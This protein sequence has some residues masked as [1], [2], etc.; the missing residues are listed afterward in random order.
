MSTANYRILLSLGGLLALLP[1]S[2]SAQTIYIPDLN[3]RTWLNGQVPGSVDVNGYM[4]TAWTMQQTPPYPLAANI[5]ITW[6]PSDLTGIQY[7]QNIVF[8]VEYTATATSTVLP[9]F[10][11]SMEALFLNHYP[12]TTLP[13]LPDVINQLEVYDCPAL[14]TLPPFLQPFQML[15]LSHL[16]Q[17]SSLPPLA[18][19]GNFNSQINLL[20]LP[21][22]TSLPT[23]SGPWMSMS[24]RSLPQVTSL[25]TLPS[26]VRY[27]TLEDMPTFTTLPAALPADLQYLWCRHL[28]SLTGLPT[29]APPDLRNIE[30]LD[31]PL[32]TDMIGGL[33]N[34]FSYLLLEDL[35]LFNQP[36]DLPASTTALFLRELPL[37]PL[38]VPVL[39]PYFLELKEL[40]LWTSIPDTLFAQVSELGLDSMLT[41][42]SLPTVLSANLD[43]VAV[44]DCPNLTCLPHLPNNFRI[45]YQEGGSIT[46]VPN[47]TP[48]WDMGQN[49]P[50]CTPLNS[51]CALVN[52]L[53]TGHIYHDLNAN[54]Q[55][56]AGEPPAPYVMVQESPQN[57]LTSGDTSG[58][59]ELPL[60]PV[61]HTLTAASTNPYVVSIAPASHT[62]ALLNLTDVDS[63]N[64]FGVVLQPNV[65]DLVTTITTDPARPGFE[66]EVWVQCTNV[67]TVP[68]G[69][70]VSFTFDSDQSWVN[71]T[72]TP[73]T[74]TGNTATWSVAPLPLGGSAVF[75][76]TLHT[77]SAVA[78]GTAIGHTASA[79]PI[80]TDATPLDNVFN[81]TDSVVGSYD[82]NDKRVVPEAMLPADVAAGERLT[83]TI[84]FQNTGTY[85]AERVVITDALSSDLVHNSL[86]VTASSHVCTWVLVDGVLRFTF[87]PINLPDSASD[88][89]GSNGFVTFSIRPSATLLPG[90]QVHNHA[91]IF[92]D[93]N[94]PVVTAP[95]VFTVIDLSGIAEVHADDLLIFPNPATDQVFVARPKDVFGPMHIQLLDPSGRSIARSTHNG[96]GAAALSVAGCASGAYVLEVHSGTERWHT[97]LHVQ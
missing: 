45:L 97:V 52:P 4:D 72:P 20:D 79:E 46:C 59:F 34:D 15:D 90:E 31:L 92:F 84:R 54:G 62:A 60:D 50:L 75:A 3:T 27:L 89:S 69:G 13:V 44:I 57:S 9:A 63:L 6:D 94:L 95:A 47:Y 40:P 41:I 85:P 38:P 19:N 67:G 33:P 61:T 25:P 71:A 66:N 53:A 70:T 80:A 7:V 55:R 10:P 17:L 30:L 48:W 14:T 87:D 77:D 23:L 29:T 81:L 37:L 36:L 82:P 83:Y 18:S 64:D 22:L 88:Q 39:S 43:S 74:L 24:L 12:G 65:E 78:L 16:P 96:P 56:D 8:S 5:D 42:S 51:A 35:P 26:S 32:V 11:A 58:Y 1:L 93:Y 28:P 73:G 86:A 76:I 68:H 91:N 2:S 49:V 21:S